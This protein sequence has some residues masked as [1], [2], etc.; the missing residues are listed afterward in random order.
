VY[1]SPDAE[2][3]ALRVAEN[4][5]DCGS[6]YENQWLAIMSKDGKEPYHHP[7]DSILS[8]DWHPD[9]RLVILKVNPTGSL[10]R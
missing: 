8:Y 9:G 4:N 1:L 10:L 6:S 5:M 2:R 3:V 7:D